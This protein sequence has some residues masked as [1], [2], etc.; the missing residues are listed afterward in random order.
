MA[1]R[2]F[3]HASHSYEEMREWVSISERYVIEMWVNQGV[4]HEGQAIGVPDR[5]R[6]GV[7]KM[8]RGEQS[9]RTH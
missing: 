6:P 7:G 5:V 3:L 1:D 9:T 2:I 4:D 8:R